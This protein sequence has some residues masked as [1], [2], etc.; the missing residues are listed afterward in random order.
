MEAFGSCLWCSDSSF[1]SSELYPFL[2]SKPSV[3]SIESKRPKWIE[4]AKHDLSVC[5]DCMEEYHHAVKDA[6]A[7]DVRFASEKRLEMMKLV[8]DA[9]VSRLQSYLFATLNELDDG[10]LSGE[11][12]DDLSFASTQRALD[13]RKKLECSL[14]EI[15]QF[16][17]LLLNPAVNDLFTRAIALL[18]RANQLIEVTAKHPGIYL[19]V[20]H[21][22]QMVCVCATLNY[23]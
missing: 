1:A 22:D 3:A 2:M 18:G 4:Q 19:L 13:M 10:S 21:P 6:F 17:R 11:E 14:I 5:I 20:V 16:P 23:P 8:Y 12:D 15:V 9:N 7:N